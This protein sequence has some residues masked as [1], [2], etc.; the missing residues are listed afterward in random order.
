MTVSWPARQ[1]LVH[2]Q[3]PRWTILIWRKIRNMWLWVVKLALSTIPGRILFSDQWK[4]CLVEDIIGW[5]I[6]LHSY[7]RFIEIAFCVFCEFRLHSMMAYTHRQCL[8]QRKAWPSNTTK[9]LGRKNWT[10]NLQYKSVNRLYLWSNCIS[11]PTFFLWKMV[12]I[13]SHFGLPTNHCA[14][15]YRSDCTTAK[16]ELAMFHWTYMNVLYNTEVYDDWKTEG[17]YDE[18]LEYVW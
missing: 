17:C 11:C 13:L 8:Y 18:I 10:G 5:L 6:E 7:C 3:T 9:E 2:T 4:M 16:S 12:R 15:I 14:F 1:I